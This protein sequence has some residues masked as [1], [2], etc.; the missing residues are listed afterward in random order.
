MALG[1]PQR[2]DNEGRG[3]SKPGNR[4]AS[5]TS[6]DRRGSMAAIRAGASAIACS[7]S[8]TVAS[9]RD[10]SSS[11]KRMTFQPRLASHLSPTRSPRKVVRNLLASTLHP[12]TRNRDIAF[13]GEPLET[14]KKLGLGGALIE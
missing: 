2:H 13:A 9:R 10:R 7:H 11:T 14:G 6:G 1:L 8:R 5:A 4:R 12:A 3:G